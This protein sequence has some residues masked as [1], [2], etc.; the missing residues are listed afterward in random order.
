[1][2]INPWKN[3]RK[4]VINKFPSNMQRA[5]KKKIELLAIS[6]QSLNWFGL[7]LYYFSSLALKPFPLFYRPILH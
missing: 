1:M 4:N 7:Y 3:N 5:R 6:S 2:M